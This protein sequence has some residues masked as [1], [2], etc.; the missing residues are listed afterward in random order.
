[1]HFTQKKSPLWS[2]NDWGKKKPSF[3]Y[4]K[5]LREFVKKQSTEVSSNPSNGENRTRETKLA[6]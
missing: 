2:Q 3:F 5:E 1:M 6:C 4:N